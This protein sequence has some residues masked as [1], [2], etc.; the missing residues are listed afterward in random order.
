M[1]GGKLVDPDKAYP[2]RGT[3]GSISRRRA[4][5]MSDLIVFAL[6]TDLT[7]VFSFMFTCSACHGNYADAGLDPVTFHE[8]YGHRLSPKGLP[9]ATTGWHLSVRFA[10]ADAWR[11]QQPL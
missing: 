2:T 11:R 8:D 4:Q 6:A 9:S 3:D 5:A 10:M 7:R 1:T